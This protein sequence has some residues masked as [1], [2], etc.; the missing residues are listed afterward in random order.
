MAETTQANDPGEY[1]VPFAV[2]AASIKGTPDE[3]FT[4]LL[5]I[6]SGATP[7]VPSAWRTAV[8]ALRDMP[9]YGA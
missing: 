2:F 6:R 9:A 4:K 1:P 8:D 7:R 3:V 5:K